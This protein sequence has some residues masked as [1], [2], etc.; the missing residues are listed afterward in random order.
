MCQAASIQ[1][2]VRLGLVM[3]NGSAG[4]SPSTGACA[5]VV[6]YESSNMWTVRRTLYNRPC[7]SLGAAMRKVVDVRRLHNTFARKNV[8]RFAGHA[9][10]PGN[11]AHLPVDHSAPRCRARQFKLNKQ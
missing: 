10:P 11:H 7:Q 5:C 1:S 3:T 4:M 8:A 6:M 2:V 9:D